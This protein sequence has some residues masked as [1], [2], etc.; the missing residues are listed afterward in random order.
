[1][2]EE[3]PDLTI[4]GWRAWYTDGRM[5]NSLTTDWVDLPAEGALVFTLY[6]RP[7]K[8]RRIMCGVTL[9]W[10]DDEKYCCDNTADA[11]IPEDL[12]AEFVKRGKWVTDTELEAART[13]A[14]AAMESPDESL[15]TE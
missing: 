11:D 14:F 13:A 1:M 12:P 8:R 7:R 3:R 6:Q 15:R 5:Y 10:K 2:S 9:Y 4:V